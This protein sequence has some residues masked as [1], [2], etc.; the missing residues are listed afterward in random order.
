MITAPSSPALNS[1]SFLI[2][3]STSS[4]LPS[5]SI[6][7]VMIEKKNHCHSIHGFN[8]LSFLCTPSQE[9][10][11]HDTDLHRIL[12]FLFLS[13]GSNQ[14]FLEVFA[15]KR[16]F[17]AF[18]DYFFDYFFDVFFDVF[19]SPTRNRNIHYLS[20]EVSYFFFTFTL[21]FFLDLT[22]VLSF[23]DPFVAYIPLSCANH[24]NVKGLSPS[25]S[26]AHP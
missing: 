2:T 7:S 6:S 26:Y 14:A 9:L 21:L 23:V 5:P 10:V 20:S 15:S 16:L 8:S 11:I 19:F 1:D 22:P 4:A 3:E 24:G 18:F 12:S 25:S 13:S 17:V